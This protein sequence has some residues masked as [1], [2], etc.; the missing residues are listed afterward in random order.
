MEGHQGSE[1]K[2][3]IPGLGKGTYKMNW[4]IVLFQKARKL[5]KTTRAGSHGSVSNL[6]GL[7]RAEEEIAQHQKEWEDAREPAHFENWLQ[8]QGPVTIKRNNIHDLLLHI[9][10]RSQM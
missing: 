7:P 1:E 6:K 4:S 8:K 3:L 5:P 9:L 10:H 2:G